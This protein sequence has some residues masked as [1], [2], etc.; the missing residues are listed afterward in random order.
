MEKSPTPLIS[1]IMPLYNTERFIRE[2]IDSVLSQTFTNFE[3]IIIDDCSSDSSVKIVQSCMKRDKRIVLLKNERNLGAARSRNRGINAA[4]GKFIAFL[5]ADDLCA[6]ERFEKQIAFL[7]QNAHVDVCGSFYSIFDDQKGP[8]SGE[9]CL[10]PVSPEEIRYQIFFINPLGLS[11]VMLRNDALKQSGIRFQECVAEDYRLWADLSDKL[12]M[13]NIPECL[14]YYRKWDAQ[15]ST[16]RHEQQ[17]ACAL[18]VQRGL[19]ARRLGI[20]LSEEETR[21][22]SHF[23]LSPD[24]LKR[25][26]LKFFRKLS[27][28][29]CLAYG[30]REPRSQK[31]LKQFLLHQYLA[32]CT[33][34]YPSWI[35]LIRKELFR[36]SLR[37]S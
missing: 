11:T 15:T 17:K 20:H 31:G 33:R 1:V 27:I 36:L 16:Q 23:T 9:C 25:Q 4:T 30:Q 34:F 6:P 5:D 26:D 3:L 12:V 22:F 2:S 37:L 7:E 13:A 21:I 28:Q 8:D 29:F 14:I 18:E 32:Y 10:L 24:K 35:I 19:L